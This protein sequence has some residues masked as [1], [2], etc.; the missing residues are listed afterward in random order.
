[1]PDIFLRHRVSGE[2]LQLFDVAR[3][4]YVFAGPLG[5]PARGRLFHRRELEPDPFFAVLEQ[6]FIAWHD[7]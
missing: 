2:A 5:D 6:G 4:D 7:R 3:D 1:M